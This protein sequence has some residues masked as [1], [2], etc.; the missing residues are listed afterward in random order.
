M[1]QIYYKTKSAVLQVKKAGFPDKYCSLT[2]FIRNRPIIVAPNDQMSYVRRFYRVFFGIV[3]D[4]IFNHDI[5]MIMTAIFSPFRAYHD[6]VF[7]APKELVAA[8]PHVMHDTGLIPIAK[9]VVY[10]DIRM[11]KF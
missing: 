10:Y 5:F 7:A 6:I 9:Q 2:A 1:I 8:D 4:I 11:F 3:K